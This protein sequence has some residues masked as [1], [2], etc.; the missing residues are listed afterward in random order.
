MSSLKKERRTL[1]DAAGKLLGLA[2]SAGAEAA[3]VCA[4]YG[5]RTKIAMEK[6]DFHLASSDA[7]YT[8]GVRVLLGGRQGFASCNTTDALELKEIALRAVEIA[9]FSPP[10][11]NNVIVPSEN[12]PQSAPAA[13]W[14]ET[15]ASL[16]LQTQKEWTKLMADEAMKDPR[17]R[18]NEGGVTTSNS[19]SLVLNSKGTHKTEQDCA[20]YWTVMGMAVDGDQITSF[21][22]FSDMSRQFASIPEKIHRSVRQFCGRVL[23]GLRTGP[24]KSYRGLVVFTPRAVC[25]ILTSALAYHLNGRVLAEKNSRWRQPTPARRCST[26]N[27]PCAIVRG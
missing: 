25:D 3:E 14:D 7:G 4:T 10:N 20:L 21:D 19:L 18:L 8:L 2:M 27:L 6:Q 13:T 11:P 17:F 9:G 24:A 23:E 22:Y 1:E 15:L 12:I 16:S 26:P 5:Q